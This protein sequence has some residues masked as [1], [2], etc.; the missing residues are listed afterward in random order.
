MIS[1]YLFSRKHSPSHQAIWWR[2]NNAGYTHRIERAGFYTAAEIAAAPDYYHNGHS[3]I[4]VP[5]ER[6]KALPHVRNHHADTPQPDMPA[7][8]A[9]VAEFMPKEAV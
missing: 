9:L 4:A 1:Y 6:V 5:V 8:L 7:V 2:P 3:T